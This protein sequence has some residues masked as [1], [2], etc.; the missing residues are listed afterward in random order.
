MG[1]KSAEEMHVDDVDDY[2]YDNPADKDDYCPDVDDD[3]DAY[4]NLLSVN[5]FD[6]IIITTYLMIM[7]K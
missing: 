6:E 7:S 2:N 4:G 5:I 1:H 3:Q